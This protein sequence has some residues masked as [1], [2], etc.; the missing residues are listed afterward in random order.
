MFLKSL[1]FH[2]FL[3]LGIVDASDVKVPKSSAALRRPDA[4]RLEMNV[5]RWRD[6]A[7]K[8]V[9]AGDSFEKVKQVIVSKAVDF[10]IVQEG[11]TGHYT[12]RCKMD[13]FVIVTVMF[14]RFDRVETLTAFLGPERWLKDPNGE[15][16]WYASP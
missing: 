15:I 9:R 16:V 12:L 3:A 4:A 7:A 14:S 5:T 10:G 11:G 6:F 8:E 1:I 2:L 13:D